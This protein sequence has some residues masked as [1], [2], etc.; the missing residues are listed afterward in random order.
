MMVGLRLAVW[1]VVFL[2]TPLDAKAACQV[3]DLSW[4]TGR[5][6]FHNGT[7][8]GEET[9]NFSK[10]R[11]V[12]FTTGSGAS[13]SG[14]VVKLSAI[15]SEQGALVLRMRFFDWSLKHALEDKDAPVVFSASACG[16]SFVQFDGVGGEYTRY[17]CSGDDMTNTGIANNNGKPGQYHVL[18]IREK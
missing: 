6:N 4:M 17:E 3:S 14:G 13:P 8:S 2:G 15:S 7:Y 10:S 11:L 9:W 5:W 1:A 16:P 12:G 18:L